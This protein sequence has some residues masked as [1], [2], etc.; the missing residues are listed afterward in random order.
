[1]IYQIDN[2]GTVIRT[3]PTPVLASRG[4]TWDSVTG[5]LWQADDSF[6]TGGIMYQL[7]P[8]DGTVLEQFNPPPGAG[9]PWPAIV[10]SSMWSA[11]MT[12]NLLREFSLGN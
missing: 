11:S 9:C 6:C 8:A 10:G 3:I 5:T 2:T 12:D 1:M 4:I 7:D